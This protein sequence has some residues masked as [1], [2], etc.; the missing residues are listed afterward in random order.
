MARV[1]PERPGGVCCGGH[2]EG[3]DAGRGARRDELVGTVRW[4]SQDDTSTIAP[5]GVATAASGGS[6]AAG[7]A[8]L[9]NEEKRDVTADAEV[10]PT[11]EAAADESASAEEEANAT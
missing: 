6:A 8:T 5:L 2:V 3:G 9:K 10:G 4:G 11:N 7:A 1:G